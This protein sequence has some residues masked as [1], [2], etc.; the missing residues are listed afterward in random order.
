MLKKRSSTI[1][2]YKL[3][4]KDHDDDGWFTEEKLDD[5]PLLAG[6]EEE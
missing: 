1:Q 4:H 3:K 6:D 5:L 2:T